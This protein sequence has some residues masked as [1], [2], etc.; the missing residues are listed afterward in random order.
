MTSDI[1]LTVIC[2]LR[3][4]RWRRPSYRYEWSMEVLIVVVIVRNLFFFLKKKIVLQASKFLNKSASQP[5]DVTTY[6]NLLYKK[7]NV[8]CVAVGRDLD[9]CQ[10]S[11]CVHHQPWWTIHIYI[12]KPKPLLNEEEAYGSGMSKLL[13][14]DSEPT[15]VVH[16]GPPGQKHQSFFVFFFCRNCNRHDFACDW[17]RQDI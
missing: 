8:R 11:L 10:D 4:W 5:D 17:S 2:G 15:R 12:Y 7:K 6:I 16:D 14:D 13:C 9:F 3:R 1:Y